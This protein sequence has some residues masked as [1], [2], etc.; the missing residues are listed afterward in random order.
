MPR[1]FRRRD[2]IANTGEIARGSL[3]ISDV[4]RTA[5]VDADALWDLYKHNEI[6]KLI[7]RK[8]C[9]ACFHN[10]FTEDLPKPVILELM[11]A[12]LY[13]RILGWSVVLFED[14][15]VQAWNAYAKSVGVKVASYDETGYPETIDVYYDAEDHGKKWTVSGRNEKFFVLRTFDGLPGWKGDSELLALYKTLNRQEAILDDYGTYV[16]L[17]GKS[18]I[19]VVDSGVEGAPNPT[20]LLESTKNALTGKLKGGEIVVAGPD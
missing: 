5:T 11:R 15:N 13:K 6:A 14:G 4:Q 16:Y 12:D 9:K 1:W 19:H 17:W 7:I 10:G 18:L 20:A 2:G 8:K 3:T